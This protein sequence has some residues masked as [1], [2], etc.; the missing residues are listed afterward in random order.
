M[1]DSGQTCWLLE[2]VQI[3]LEEALEVGYWARE[4][5]CS[6]AK[7]R[8]AV[9]KVGANAGDVRRYFQS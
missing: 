3:D 5:G 1:D 9:K 7:L 4:F 2:A 6:A 8:A